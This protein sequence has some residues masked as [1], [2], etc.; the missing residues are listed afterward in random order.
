MPSSPPPL[1]VAGR[2][3]FGFEPDPDDGR[4]ACVV[5]FGAGVATVIT[6]AGAAAIT[7]PIATGGGASVVTVVGG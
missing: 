1:G 7:P 6:G 5:G 2:V 4:A 3:V